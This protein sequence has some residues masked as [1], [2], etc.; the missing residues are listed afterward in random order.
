[1][2]DSMKM[3]LSMEK[4][5]IDGAMEGFLKENGLMEKLWNL[6]KRNDGNIWFIFN[7]KLDIEYI[8]TD[9]DFSK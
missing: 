3:V 5:N 7:R 6:R 1:M 8:S 2:K 9:N 4:E